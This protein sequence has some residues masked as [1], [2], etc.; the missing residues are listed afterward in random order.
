METKQYK[1]ERI[2]VDPEF[3]GLVQP[4]H[5]DELRQLEANI[6][7]DGI[8]EPLSIWMADG[9]T[10][11]LLDGHNRRA[12]AET[13]GMAEVP[14]HYVKLPDRDSAL[15]W[16][17]T[18]Q[19]GRRNLTDDQRA[20]IW[21]SILD[22][23]AK[24]SRAAQL[25][26]ARQAKSDLASVEAKIAPTEK[27]D[28]LAIYTPPSAE[29]ALAPAP[30]PGKLSPLSPRDKRLIIEGIRIGKQR[31]REKIAAESGL[32]ENKLCDA[33]KLKKEAPEL[34][35]EVR[36]GKKT[37]RQAKKAAK[38]KKT[39]PM[40]ANVKE[41]DVLVIR[42]RKEEFCALVRSGSNKSTIW[43]NG[44]RF[45][46]ATGCS[47]TKHTFIVRVA[48]D[49]ER[50]KYG[51]ERAAKEEEERQ[52]DAELRQASALVQT[53]MAHF[54]PQCSYSK[55][56]EDGLSIRFHNLTVEHVRR[57][58]AA[59]TESAAPT[60]E[61][62]ATAPTD[63]LKQCRQEALTARREASEDWDN[64][65]N[66]YDDLV[67]KGAPAEVI[68]EAKLVMDDAERT[69]SNADSAFL[70][71]DSALRRAGNVGLS[72]PAPVESVPAPEPTAPEPEPLIEVLP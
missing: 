35:K 16:I 45:S 40:L 7:R 11:T 46:R 26:Q 33:A 23:R 61:T 21:A 42:A 51:A 27:T 44:T 69:S 70:A 12:I 34:A 68:D 15:L 58:V 66:S 9:T 59:L 13:L 25:E 8:R 18:N 52:H 56:N 71:L 54:T 53:L 60:A 64:A 29:T 43:V 5:P 47:D 62:P 37:I 14:V 36:E 38:A 3:A 6:R 63:V 67:E 22:R 65:S 4:L 72:K 31:E 2:V 39:P 20:M 48:T 17:E 57:I 55:Y 32:S 28:A 49:A 19:I 1:I 30:A 10:P 24:A 41:G 50:D